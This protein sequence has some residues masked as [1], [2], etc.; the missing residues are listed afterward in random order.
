M[1]QH[2]HPTLLLSNTTLGEQGIINKRGRNGRVWGTPAHDTRQVSGDKGRTEGGS[3]WSMTWPLIRALIPSRLGSSSAFTCSVHLTMLIHCF[4]LG[5]LSLER[6]VFSCSKSQVLPC[7]AFSVT[8][9]LQRC[10]SWLQ[11][12]SFLAP[13]WSVWCPGACF[14][15][16]Q[17]SHPRR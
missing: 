11:T 13:E 6:H 12:H 16:E 5:S 3:T 1:S 15:W 8:D 7:V 2:S 10:F 4:N 17:V 14:L 9:V